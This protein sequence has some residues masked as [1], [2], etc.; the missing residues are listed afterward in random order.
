[1]SFSATR[2]ILPGS[3][4]NPDITTL[5]FSSTSSYNFSTKA[6]LLNYF[7]WGVVIS[8][9]TGLGRALLGLVHMIIHLVAAIFSTLKDHHLK[10]AELGAW[11]FGFGLIEMIPIIGNIA[12][13]LINIKRQKHYEKLAKDI[14]YANPAGYSNQAVLFAYG[15]EIDRKQIT[16]S[17]DI[18]DEC[19][20]LNT[21]TEMLNYM[22]S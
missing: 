16:L 7:G 9:I 17:N 4:K 12:M 3:L 21:S 18:I 19:R 20:N 2:N 1:M 5:A 22:A 10:E 15:K 11:N 13:A 8:T 14:V 6:H